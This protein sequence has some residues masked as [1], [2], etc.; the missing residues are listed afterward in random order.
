MEETVEYKGKTYKLAP[1]T[2]EIMAQWESYLEGRAWQ[3]LDRSKNFREPADYQKAA[4]D[5]EADIVAGK[6][7]FF[8]EVSMEAQQGF[9][10]GG[11]FSPGYRQMAYLRLKI[12]HP[13]VDDKFIWDMT[14]DKAEEIMAKMRTMDTDP[15]PQEPVQTEAPAA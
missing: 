2:V 15:N 9:Q 8:S 5:L 10:S 3:A 7:G 12:N 1:M 6:Y 4:R 14:E 11:V 13:E